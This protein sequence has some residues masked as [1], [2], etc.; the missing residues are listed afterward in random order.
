MTLAGTTCSPQ[1]VVLFA[2]SDKG[3]LSASKVTRTENMT[4]AQKQKTLKICYKKVLKINEMPL[5]ATLAN[6]STSATPVGV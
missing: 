3:A 4:D 1:M 5:C 6:G 2:N